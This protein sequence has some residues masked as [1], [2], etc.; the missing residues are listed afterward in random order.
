[1][2]IWLD[3]A[4]LD[5]ARICAELGFIG[6]I[7]TN[8]ALLATAS[9]SAP[10]QIAAL[11]DV[12]PG[13]VCYQL[14]QTGPAA[15]D[16]ATRIRRLSPR[17]VVLKIPAGLEMI[18]L[19]ARVAERG[20]WALTATFSPAQTALACAAGARYV[21]PYV[22]R[23]T[24][25]NGNGLEI[26]GQMAAICRHANTGTEVLAASVKSAEEAVSALLAGAHHITAPLAIIRAMAEH[27]LSAQ[28]VDDFARVAP[29]I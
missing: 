19:G 24:R 10:E 29:A 28:A 18:A 4:D 7:T 13:P 16:E 22:N 27:P 14:T 15:D 9:R 1:M 21:I 3:S 17:R 11:L 5:D 26:T 20:Q 8:P 23:M 12:F 6:G 25:L 2:A